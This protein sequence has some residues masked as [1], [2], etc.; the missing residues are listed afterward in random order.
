MNTLFR[1]LGETGF[2]V[3]RTLLKNWPFL[4]ASVVLATL[5]RHY[6][7]S[8]RIAA[9]L[10]RHQKAGVLAA[11]AAAVGTPLC[12]CGTTAVVIGMMASRLPWA[13]VIAF[14]VSSPLT[15]PQELIYS[16]G[17]FGWPF[18]AA[19]FAASIVLGLGGGLAGS[20]FEKRGWLAGQV[21]FQKDEACGSCGSCGSRPAHGRIIMDT[22]KTG[23][24]LLLVFLAFTFVGYF[25]NRLIPG[26]WITAIF[27]KNRIYG[28]PLAATLGLPFYI[29]SEVSL[30]LVRAMLAAGMSPGAA[31]AFL[32]TGAG[33]SIGAVS[34]AL[35][36]ARWRVIGLVVVTLWLGAMACGFAFDHGL[37]AGLF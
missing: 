29:N 6:L 28:I 2:M 12:S 14:M 11:T 32:I 22:G 35:A 7:D 3:W 1:L 8:A 31:L 16:A 34:G 9:F 4:L 37:A 23:L 21:R 15:S 10:H 18:A 26:H 19:F 17:L 27:G 13:P 24:R 33:T 36:I 25:V 30:P 5:L 20:I